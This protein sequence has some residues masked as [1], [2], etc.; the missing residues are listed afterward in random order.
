M[1]VIDNVKMPG[2]AQWCTSFVAEVFASKF[3]QIQ[4]EEIETVIIDGIDAKRIYC[5]AHERDFII[6]MWDFTPC[7]WDSDGNVCGEMVAYT[8]FS[9][10][11]GY[12]SHKGKLTA[13]GKPLADGILKI[14]VMNTPGTNKRHGSVQKKESMNYERGKNMMQK[15]TC[16]DG[17]VYA[18]PED[19]YILVDELIDFLEPYRG[20]LFWNGATE[21]FSFR[22]DEDM[23]VCDEQNFQLGCVSEDDEELFEA[24]ELFLESGN[25][26]GTE[27][28]WRKMCIE[29]DADD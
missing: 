10:N 19:Q 11:T 27:E 14:Q 28:E 23:V 1:T 24:I 6:R 29:E 25:E 5:S 2:Y 26:Y 12:S 13:N 22:V 20:K 9:A 3:P 16:V 4:G 7:E 21:Q 15:F 18:I 17:T 8:F